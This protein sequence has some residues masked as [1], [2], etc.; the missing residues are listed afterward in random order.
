MTHMRNLQKNGVTIKI[1]DSLEQLKGSLKD[2]PVNA[3]LKLIISS[4]KYSKY[5]EYLTGSS[6]FMLKLKMQ[7]DSTIE[8]NINEGKGQRAE[9]IQSNELSGNI[10]TQTLN[11]NTFNNLKKAILKERNTN[12]STKERPTKTSRISMINRI[13]AISTMQ[14]DIKATISDIDNN[15]QSCEYS[16][17][18]LCVYEDIV[19]YGIALKNQNIIIVLNRDDILSV[20]TSI[21]RIA[22]SLFKTGRNKWVDYNS[23]YEM[24]MYDILEP[25]DGISI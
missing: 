20:S 5:I 21:P 1:I 13:K 15:L 11:I 19:I 10:D 25:G 24:S 2:K 14:S 7:L 9:D 18:P 16:I 17:H 3:K 6:E 22:N 4:T 12:E 23:I 8:Y